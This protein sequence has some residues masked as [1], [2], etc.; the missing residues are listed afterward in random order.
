MLR[1]G[2][3][4]LLAASHLDREEHERHQLEHDIDHGRHVDVLVALFRG[5]AAK[6]HRA[7]LP[8]RGASRAILAYRGK[9][10]RIDPEREP[11]A[12]RWSGDSNSSRISRKS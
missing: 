6:K 5:L 3:V 7:N 4:D 11:G 9:T 8:L 10:A 1:G 2:H 12:M